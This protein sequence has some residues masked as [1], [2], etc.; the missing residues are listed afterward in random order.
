MDNLIKEYYLLLKRTSEYR[1]HHG[2]T[3]VTYLVNDEGEHYELGYD[4]FKIGSTNNYFI[5]SKED[6]KLKTFDP[7]GFTITYG[8][9]LT[10]VCNLLRRADY[11][12]RSII[13]NEDKWV[14]NIICDRKYEKMITLEYKDE[15]SPYD[16]ARSEI[17]HHLKNLTIR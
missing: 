14:Y 10:N 5:Y 8:L 6:N 9:S 16:W 11:N 1:S 17:V 12:I 13:F 15:R 2:N 4:V 3:G 7:T